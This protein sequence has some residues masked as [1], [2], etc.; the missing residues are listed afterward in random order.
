MRR[1][2]LVPAVAAAA[3][4]VRAPD[5]APGTGA[6]TVVSAPPRIGS[7]TVVAGGTMERP[8]IYEMRADGSPLRTILTNGWD[9]AV[10]PDGNRIAFS[11][12]RHGVTELYLMKANGTH[13][14]RITHGRQPHANTA[15]A[16]SPDGKRIVFQHLRGA[17]L[18]R[19]DIWIVTPRSGDLERVTRSRA[20][21]MAPDWSP[22][23]TAVAFAS[24]RGWAPNS[25]GN[26]DVWIKDIETEELVR[27]TRNLAYESNPSWSPDGSG[28]AFESDRGDPRRARIWMKRLGGAP[29]RLTHGGRLGDRQPD[30]SPDGSRIVFV[31]ARGLCVLELGVGI[32]TIARGTR[33]RVY[34]SP[35]WRST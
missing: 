35:S 26:W 13:V 27:F 30:W 33:E 8:G 32:T 15:P 10:S 24:E 25:E 11:V 29:R 20:L 14:R 2:I 22:D 9:P 19:S 31:R 4:L 3:L 5:P 16:W 6:L 28:I 23:G 1:A 34:A 21:D 17:G 12:T 18:G 7:A